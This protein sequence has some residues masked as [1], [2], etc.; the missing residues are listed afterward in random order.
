MSQE[1]LPILY[2][3]MAGEMFYIIEQ[4]LDA[5]NIEQSKKIQGLFDNCWWLFSV[6]MF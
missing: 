1:F 4:R 3:N 5:Q 2:F 6:I